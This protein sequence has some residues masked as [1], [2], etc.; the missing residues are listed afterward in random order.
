MSCGSQV[1]PL[2]LC[3]EDDELEDELGKGTVEWSVPGQVEVYGSGK[4]NTCPAKEIAV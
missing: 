3:F 2:K 1:R 4:P